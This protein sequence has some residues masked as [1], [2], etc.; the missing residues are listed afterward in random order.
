MVN[1]ISRT[2]AFTN[3]LD[4]P[5]LLSSAGATRKRCESGEHNLEVG[6][7]KAEFQQEACRCHPDV[8][9]P[10]GELVSSAAPQATAIC[11]HP[12]SWTRLMGCEQPG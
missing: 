2:T 11:E 3:F 7:L 4:E 8:G 5:T 9:T 12:N 6:K 10:H 1:V